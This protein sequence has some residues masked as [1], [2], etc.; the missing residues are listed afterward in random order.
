[1]PYIPHR[2]DSVPPLDDEDR[3]C[4]VCGFGIEVD[5]TTETDRV[6]VSYTVTGTVWHEADVPG[7]RDVRNIDKTVKDVIPAWT[8]C[9][10]CGSN[11]WQSG[12]KRGSL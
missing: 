6:I 5:R 3:P 12:G 2:Y 11:R 9:P 10:L 4:D 8:N 7:P 1:M